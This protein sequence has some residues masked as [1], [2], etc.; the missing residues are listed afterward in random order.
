MGAGVVYAVIIVMWAIVL[1]PMWLQRHDQT[2]E[3]RSEARF[4]GAMRSLSRSE[5][6]DPITFAV[7]VASPASAAAA[8]RRTVFLGLTLAVLLA[9]VGA[10]FGLAP[11]WLAG[12]PM[13]LLFGFLLAAWQAVQRSTSAVV[14]R[15]VAQ[16]VRSE[17]V[18]HDSLP[19]AP[20]VP[21][22]PV[23]R[24]G[25]WVATS[26]PLPTYVTAPA[27]TR[28]PRLLDLRTPGQWTSA[29]MLDQV[30]AQ[31]QA[32]VQMRSFADLFVDDARGVDVG[33]DTLEVVIDRRTANG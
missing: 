33:D 2:S 32:R 9:V 3:V 10:M 31:R 14:G 27:A 30:Q 1:I 16:P 7:P 13:L 20:A 11:S 6:A 19:I 8:R 23:L 22:A 12:V 25:E 24:P 17:G 21:T 5:V 28:I 4:R 15:R 29:A 18:R 26:T